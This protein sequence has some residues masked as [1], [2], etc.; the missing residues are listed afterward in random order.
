M[1][2]E[3][4]VIARGESRQRSSLVTTEDLKG[5][6]SAKSTKLAVGHKI[7]VCAALSSLA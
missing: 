5:W 7:S 1:A 2:A 6:C 3:D 4:G